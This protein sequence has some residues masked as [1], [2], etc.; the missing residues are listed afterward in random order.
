MLKYPAERA[1]R[2][3]RCPKTPAILSLFMPPSRF[4]KTGEPAPT[5]TGRVRDDWMGSNVAAR[6]ALLV[7]YFNVGEG[8]I[9]ALWV[10]K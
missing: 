8:S 9:N 2:I 4:D 10:D 7:P 1:H 5:R 6:V 3:K